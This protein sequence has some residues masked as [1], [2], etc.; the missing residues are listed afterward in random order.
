[1]VK[2][3]FC[4]LAITLINFSVF[5]NASANPSIEMPTNIVFLSDS[6]NTQLVDLLTVDLSQRDGIKILERKDIKVVLNE[7]M[8]NSFF[9]PSGG[10]IRMNTGRLLKADLIFTLKKNV[11]NGKD[12]ITLNACQTRTGLRIGVRTIVSKNDIDILNKEVSIW[13]AIMLRKVREK[14]ILVVSVPPFISDDL[15]TTKYYLQTSIPKIAEQYILKQSGI[16]AVEFDEAKTINNE[17]YLTLTNSPA[18][19]IPPYY[20]YGRFEHD[21][22][23]K[24]S[25][26]S[27]S[28]KLTLG[29]QDVANKSFKGITEKDIPTLLIDFLKSNLEK[30]ISKKLLV[31]DSISEAK[32]LKINAEQFFSLGNW[33]E[34]LMIAE[35]SLLLNPNQ[36]NLRKK[37]HHGGKFL[38]TYDHIKKITLRKDMSE[39]IPK[40]AFNNE[41]ARIKICSYAQGKLCLAGSFGKTT[42]RSWI[43]IAS[44]YSDRKISIK[45]IF[46]AQ[47]QLRFKELCGI[48][49]IQKNNF[50]FNPLKLVL[51]R[52]NSSY[53]TSLVL[54]SKVPR[55]IYPKQEKMEILPDFL[56][57]LG[58]SLYKNNS[59]YSWRYNY[60]P[61]HFSSSNDLTFYNRALFWVRDN[62]IFKLEYPGIKIKENLNIDSHTERVFFIDD[63]IYLDS[64]RGLFIA[65]SFE[66]PIR[67]IDIKLPNKPRFRMFFSSNF[68]T[69]IFLSQ[70]PYSLFKIEKNK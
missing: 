1:M 33:K 6:H 14:I 2:I 34:F 7:K 13:I 44:K 42:K 40:E 58:H 27:L 21:S 28:L 70:R 48:K 4:F 65:D 57:S 46:E 37:N 11:I 66:G 5:A 38:I 63:K 15:Q 24:N 26:L 20:L 39:T 18:R 53:E 55:I 60:I 10:A 54:I 64:Y 3:I 68:Y 9:S 29:D 17:N 59:L 51:L 67:K 19:R 45:I 32:E 35:A 31:P 49:N 8:M 52:G 50:V 12:C 62:K 23:K 22:Y 47:K 43:A 30:S 25:L 41:Y 61:Y 69:S 36:I 16:L 56:S